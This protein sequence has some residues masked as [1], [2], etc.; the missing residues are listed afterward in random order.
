MTAALRSTIFAGALLSALPL[1]ASAQ[2]P[3]L[4]RSGSL[5]NAFQIICNL[6]AP[7]FDHVSA[8]AAGIRMPLKTDTSGPGAAGTT[9]KS[10][11]WLGR[12]TDGPFVLLLDQMSGSRGVDTA[13][14]VAGAVPD[15]DRF[16]DQ[17]MDELKLPTPKAP[18]LRPDG[19]RS[20]FWDNTPS[21]GLTF[22]IRDYQPAGKPGVMIKVMSMKAAA[23][24]P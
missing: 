2:T 7:A 15:V 22:L 18:E 5:I 8:Y 1:P 12:L 17:A 6:E 23:P 10:R 4:D 9:V 19:S 21:R 24:A 16:R 13:C 3:K 20:W 11:V 14:A